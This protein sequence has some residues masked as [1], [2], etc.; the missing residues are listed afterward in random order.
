MFDTPRAVPIADRTERHYA[1]FLAPIY[2]WMLGDFAQAIERSR[3]ELCELGVGTARRGARA[4]DLGA[5]LGLQ[6]MPL[7]EL[8]YEVTAVDGS[9]K[10]LSELSAA[11]P[12]ARVVRADLGAA[13][14]L[15]SGAYDVVVCMGDT[16]PHLRSVPEVRAV[17]GEASTCVTPGG[18]LLLTFRDYTGP[19]PR[20]ADR[21]ILVRG[22]ADR[23]LTC[24]LDY[25]ADRVFV[26]D[27][28]HERLEGRWSLRASTYEKLRLAPLFIASELTAHGLLVERCDSTGGRISIV[29]RRRA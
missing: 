13:G 27:V 15:A 2:R 19:P 11:C 24:H 17:L 14:P 7:V 12:R 18:L 9:E 23:I 29:A 22:D 5:G 21:F 1:T 3:A 4:L 16:L 26:T 20:P 25:A 6:T 10:L 28:L 8:G